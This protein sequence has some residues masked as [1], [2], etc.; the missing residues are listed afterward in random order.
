MKNR[1]LFLL[2]PALV[3]VSCDR[4]LEQVD[5]PDPAVM[6]AVEARLAAE[7]DQ[8]ERERE[9]IEAE[10]EELRQIREATLA[11]RESEV[12]NRELELLREDEEARLRA[13][14]MAAQQG[15]IDA[16]QGELDRLSQELSE[17]Q[18]EQAGT[19]VIEDWTP[20]E[21]EVVQQPV[22]DYNLFYDEL[23]PHG[24][25]FDTPDYGYVYQ[26]TVVIQNRSW[27]PYTRGRWVCTN[28]GWTWRSDEPFGWATFHYGRWALLEKRGWCW[29]P[30]SEWAPSWCAWR[31][32]DGHVGWAPLPPETLAYRR[33]WGASVGADLGIG[34][35][36]FNFIDR[37]HM[38]GPAYKH[39]VP[40][41]RNHHY[42]GLTRGCTNLRYQGF[43]VIAGGPSYKLIKPYIHDPWPVYQLDLNRAPRFGKGFKD[44]R[45]RK[46]H[47]T[48]NRL[49]LFAPSLDAPWNP[50]LRPQRVADRWKN[51]QVVRANAL[52]E[53][54]QRRFAEVR[55]RQQETARKLA[56]A[57]EDR[58]EAQLAQ[59]QKNREAVAAA[60]ERYRANLQRQVSLNP[61]V[62]SSANR[63]ADAVGNPRL[64][65]RPG[66]RG[67]AGGTL[68]PGVT[69]GG[70][71]P[72]TRG[73]GGNGGDG[74]DGGTVEPASPTPVADRLADLRRKQEEAR[75]QRAQQAEERRQTSQVNRETR[76][77]NTGNN[78]NNGNA[79][80]QER[81]EEARRQREVATREA[82]ERQAQ[83]RA[84]QQEQLREQQERMR[85]QQEQNR[86]KQEQARESQQARLREQQEKA[87]MA[88]EQAKQAAAERARQNQEKL[89]QQQ[90]AARRAAEERARQQQEAARK[91]AEE[92]ARQQA[93][94]ARRQEEARRAAQERARQQQEKVRQQQEQARRAAEERAR[95]QQEQARRAAEE[96]ARRQQEQQQKLREAQERMR[97]RIR[98]QQQRNK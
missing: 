54:Y 55:E 86:A 17:Q 43:Q 62:N 31:H 32:G 76:P 18:L 2:A 25:W 65:G 98:E 93:E 33:G 30:G 24:S 84:S 14:E 29:V 83:A 50:G 35:S 10:K 73:N 47:L 94:M 7:R 5:R 91:A 57:N 4:K 56:Q 49:Q 66:N 81:L 71:L 74:G 34:H 95:Q 69:R 96:R 85:Q 13:L 8:L 60:Q 64:N 39:C 23:S 87:R 97:E 67:N 77:S 89:K 42:Y 40:I 63:T 59:L 92:R 15:E 20:A 36:W 45:L 21:P 26:P 27:R 53:T 58:R 82:S 79:T 78:A 11:Q 72:I 70:E 52:K 44:H 46:G 37:R 19:G 75:Q 48:G 41:K 12:E 51:V 16:R 6:E 61:R 9:A 88:Q 1:L 80:M 3:L 28:L 38:A 22:A 68:P 90:E